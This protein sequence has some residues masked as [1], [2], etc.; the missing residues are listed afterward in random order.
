MAAIPWGVRD[1]D[2]HAYAWFSPIV[3]WWEPVRNVRQLS[4]YLLRPEQRWLVPAWWAS[5]VAFRLTAWLVMWQLWMPPRL[6]LDPRIVAIAAAAVTA[7]S[8]TLAV[9]LIHLL[10]SGVLA[11]V[12]MPYVMDFVKRPF[13]PPS[14]CSW[15]GSCAASPLPSW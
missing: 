12:R 8:T 10:T 5:W 6:L 11:R 7:I 1:P 14:R 9:I 4:T 13:P 15:S 3:M 2:W